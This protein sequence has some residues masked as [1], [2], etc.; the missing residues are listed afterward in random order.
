MK[1]TYIIFGMMVIGS[2]T[3]CNK[4]YSSPA[5][6][7]DF[8]IKA[9]VD[10]LNTKTTYNKSGST[11]AFSWVQ[12]DIISVM[13][14]DATSNRDR[15]EYQTTEATPG[16]STTFNPRSSLDS[17]WNPAEYAFYPANTNGFTYPNNT[18]SPTLT[19]GDNTVEQANPY[20]AIPMIGKNN[21]DNTF[22]FKAATGVL[23][24]TFTNLP[25]ELEGNSLTLE[26][27]TGQNGGS[28]SLSGQ[29]SFP[30]DNKTL[31][32]TSNGN[33]QKSVT[34]SVAD[35]S[36][37]SFFVPIPECTIVAKDMKIALRSTVM[38][39]TF[40][41]LYGYFFDNFV[42]PSAITITR[43]VVSELPTIDFSAI[44]ETLTFTGTPVAP[45]VTLAKGPRVSKVQYVVATSESA[46][47]SA[48]ST[49]Y[50]ELTTNGETNVPAP[51]STGSYYI[52]YRLVNPEGTYIKYGS[53]PFAYVANAND[54]AATYKV[55]GA[56]NFGFILEASDKLSYAVKM[57]QYI[58]T[59]ATYN[60]ITGNV[61]GNWNGET[62]ELSFEKNQKLGDYYVC[63]AEAINTGY[64]CTP[65]DY[66]V[67]QLMHQVGTNNKLVF[68]CGRKFGIVN[69]TYT[70]TGQQFNP[71]NYLQ[72]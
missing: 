41:S 47:V 50:E 53:I 22:S 36:S 68:S 25:A 20:A 28:T 4:D 16:A 7:K 1:K 48:F 56:P 58:S 64:V 34:M 8:S 31:T 19:L 46:G 23:K 2:L 30:A 35:A 51:A 45:K 6:N 66:L 40:S 17:K 49:S 38:T 61:Y 3:A 59:N 71:G 33:Q 12:N 15:F 63:S 43:G 9:N 29:C 60:G 13:L 69:S 14:I 21:G 37:V 62:G 70:G 55:S 67:F 5:A 11:Y 18:A 39:S 44:R 10:N 52:V 26:L 32:I 27:T 57:T 42:N 72:Q 54:L 65:D 24:V